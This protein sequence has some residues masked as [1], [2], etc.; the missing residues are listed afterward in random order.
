MIQNRIFPIKIVA[1]RAVEHYPRC[2]DYIRGHRKVLEAHGFSHFLSNEESWMFNPDTIV[3]MVYEPESGL[4]LG[5]ARFERRTKDNLLSFE[6]VLMKNE[7]RLVKHINGRVKG[8]TGEI[9]GLWNAKEVAGWNTSI[10]L[11]RSVIIAMWE[12]NMSSIFAFNARYTNRIPIRLGFRRLTIIGDN[13][14]VPYPDDRFQAAIW[15]FEKRKGLN[16]AHEYE[17]KVMKK[18]INN[19]Q[20][21]ITEG[22]VY[23]NLKVQYDLKV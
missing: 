15:R 6:R 12:Q 10:L 3:A 18:L 13:G 21:E 23:N 19:L 2:L 1:F 17:R 5:G 20:Q 14:Y 7:P 16:L 4:A 9:C 11:V 8:G 22:D